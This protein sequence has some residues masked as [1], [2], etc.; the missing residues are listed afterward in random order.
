MQ[1]LAV[2]ASA[3]SGAQYA[4][5]REPQGRVSRVRGLSRREAALAVCAA[6]TLPKLRA[7]GRS[8][9]KLHP[10]PFYD[11]RCRALRRRSSGCSA[12][13]SACGSFHVRPARPGSCA[14]ARRLLCGSVVET[15]RFW[16]L[17]D[18]EAEPRP[19]ITPR[20]CWSSRAAARTLPKCDRCCTDDAVRAARLGPV[21]L[22]GEWG[23]GSGAG[24]SVSR[25]P[26]VGRHRA[27]VYA[28]SD[29]ARR[30]ETFC[31]W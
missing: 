21:G 31:L 23:A 30:C 26:R 8:E 25:L 11:A 20:C 19:P 22:L 1:K 10:L 15:A 18:N 12:R 17:A 5:S 4:S 24:R 16:Q 6:P 29:A 27:P 3:S 7:G 9:R 28:G 13:T 14:R 2:D